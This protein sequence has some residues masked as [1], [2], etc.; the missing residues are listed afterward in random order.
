MKKLILIILILNKF[1]VL[2]QDNYNL[3]AKYWMYRDRFEK[4]FVENNNNFKAPFAYNSGNYQGNFTIT[5]NLK[6]NGEHHI[7]D[8]T[9]YEGMYI[10]VLATEYKLLKINGYDNE[11]NRTLE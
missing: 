2:S 6:T 10:G 11:A 4:Y 9:W 1:I 3:Q 8:N 7:A 5:E